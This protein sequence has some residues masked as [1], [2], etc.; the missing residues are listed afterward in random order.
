MV[1]ENNRL[2]K[3]SYTD[4]SWLYHVYDFKNK[5]VFHFYCCG[6]KKNQSEEEIANHKKLDVKELTGKDPI[7]IVTKL[8]NYMSEKGR[9]IAV[10]KDN[11]PV[12]S[13]TC[14]DL[15]NLLANIEKYV[16]IVEKEREESK[17]ISTSKL[18][19]RTKY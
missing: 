12:V 18:R 5:E 14:T 3:I 9:D 4:S 13:A 1:F 6:R 7:Y 15:K 10:S 17:L 8:I 11:K 16:E 19:C 2:F